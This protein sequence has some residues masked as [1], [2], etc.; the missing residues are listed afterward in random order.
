MFAFR[1]GAWS[2]GSPPATREKDTTNE[3]QPLLRR[4]RRGGQIWGELRLGARDR[5]FLYERPFDSLGD[6]RRRSGLD[7]CDLFR[8]VSSL[9]A[10]CENSDSKSAARRAK[11]T[12]GPA[13]NDFLA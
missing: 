9:S 8:A 1:F 11:V 12:Y 4:P 7:L 10:P 6:H 13:N 2:V 3:R 5:D